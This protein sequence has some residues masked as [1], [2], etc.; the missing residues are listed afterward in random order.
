MHIYIA[1]GWAKVIDPSWLHFA[2]GQWPTLW[3]TKMAQ[4]AFWRFKAVRVPVFFFGN[5]WA[6]NQSENEITLFLDLLKMICYFLHGKS[7][8]WGIYREY[9][10]FFGGSL[11][12]SMYFDINLWIGKFIRINQFDKSHLGWIIVVMTHDLTYSSLEWC[13]SFKLLIVRGIISKFLYDHHN[14]SY[15]GWLFQ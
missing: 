1:C 14:S 15:F 13:V 6:K 9:V 2:M 8:S 5:G 7:T 10:L 3:S 12:K 4:L 11:S